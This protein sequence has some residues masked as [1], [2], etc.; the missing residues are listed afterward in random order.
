MA[1]D[2]EIKRVPLYI[3]GLDEEI[4]GGIP[5]NHV[6]LVAGSAGTM[7]SSI[8]FNIL[9]N[10]AINGKTGLYIT[11]EQS[12]HSLLKHI[13]N[14]GFDLRATNI[15]ILDDIGKINDT[16]AKVKSIKGC[17]IITDIG[18]IRKQVKNMSDKPSGDW[19]NVIKNILKKLRENTNLSL[20][21]LDSLAALSVVSDFSENARSQLFY[22]FEFFRELMITTYLISEMPVSGTKYGQFEIEDFL[23][24]G[25]IHLELAPRMRKVDRNIRIVKMRATRVNT[26]IFTLEFRNGKFSALYGGKTPL[27]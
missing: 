1:D 8:A 26:D 6:V 27:V 5:E 11:L 17:M 22:L 12:Y 13:I 14:M 3:K 25:I 19:L 9:Y 16:I 21:C 7:K 10:E 18:A 20:F 2:F 15:V 23:A 24:D 4:Q